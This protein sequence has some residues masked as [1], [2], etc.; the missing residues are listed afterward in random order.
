[1]AKKIL[2]CEDDQPVQDLLKTIALK[3]KNEV[4]TA[5]DGKEAIEKVREI[6]PDLILLDIRMP[7]MDGLEAAKRIR[8]FNSQ[9]KI[10]FITAFQSP[11]L[12]K[13]A[14]KYDI[15]DYIVKISSTKEILKV[16]QEAVK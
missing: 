16:I 15:C 4:Y 11:E 8:K 13:E 9:V 10:V 2:I 7:K 12:T 3:S 14:A 6:N 5:Q 1:M